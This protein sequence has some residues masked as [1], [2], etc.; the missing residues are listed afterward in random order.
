MFCNFI[1][2]NLRKRKRRTLFSIFICFTSYNDK[3]DRLFAFM[4][5]IENSKSFKTMSYIE[6]YENIK[7]FK[8]EE[9]LQQKQILTQSMG[10]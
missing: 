7:N 4:S 8:I 9:K 10:V 3:D 5:Y 2:D 1:A 6:D